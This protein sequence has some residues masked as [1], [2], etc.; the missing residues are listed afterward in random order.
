MN[1]PTKLKVHMESESEKNWQIKEPLF[2]PKSKETLWALGIIGFAAI[3]F[4]ILL[5][6]Y[7]FIL[8]IGLVAF[9]I[10]SSKNK[11]VET[12]A[13]RLDKEGFYIGNKFY[14]YESFESFW[15]FPAHADLE[16]RAYRQAG[17]AT[18]LHEREFALQ[19]KTR[20]APLLVIPFHN[21]DEAAI[22]KILTA[23]L[24]ENEEQESL[25]DLLR[26][27]FF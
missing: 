16:T 19:H 6:N 15:I 10:Y 2:S 25:I 4:S 27:R 3:I 8:I 17:G 24:E 9:I 21:E 1:E 20:L 18:T 14:H 13:F 5:K 7:L 11:K 12:I 26:K 22:R 23:H